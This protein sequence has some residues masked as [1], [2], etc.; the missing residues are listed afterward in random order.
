MAFEQQ[1]GIALDKVYNSK[2]FF[3]LAQLIKSGELTAADQPMIIHTG[4]LQG[5]QFEA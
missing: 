1:H 5:G 3:A 2:S 4:G